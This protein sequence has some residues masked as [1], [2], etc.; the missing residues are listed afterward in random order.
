MSKSKAYDKATA[1]VPSSNPA[2]HIEVQ[3]GGQLVTIT[4]REEA[5][6]ILDTT[7]GIT[8]FDP[9]RFVQAAKS[10]GAKVAERF[11][12]LEEGQQMEGWLIGKGQ[13]EIEDL[14]TKLPKMVA[15]YSFE[16][17]SGARVSLL[18]NA[19]LDELDSLPYDGSAR[20]LIAKG[21]QTRT[22]K[23]RVMN[24]FYVVS[25]LNDRKPIARLAESVSA[26]S[27]EAD[28]AIGP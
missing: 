3:H 2:E 6:A 12:K 17:T 15:K 19:Q 14:N 23:G 21:G 9:M 11:A 25:W 28:G 22:K 4:S 1:A 5:L 27:A 7:D 24:E 20:V 8:E 10:Q 26:A 18:A 13:T 16:L